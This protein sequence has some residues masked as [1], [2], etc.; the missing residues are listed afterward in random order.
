MKKNIENNNALVSNDSRYIDEKDI[1]IIGLSCRFPGA[2]NANE[3]WALLKHKKNSISEI[4]NDRWDWRQYWGDPKSTTNKTNIKWGGFIK[5]VDKFDP[6]FFNISPKEAAYM[7][8]QHRLFLQTAWHAIEDAGY[9]VSGL[10]GK[11]IGVYAGVSKNDYSE[12]MREVKEDIAPFISTGTVHS[13]LANRLSFLFDFHG[14][15]MAIDT[16][17]SSGLV[18][19]HNAVR[20]IHNGECEAAIVGAVNTLL[21]PT[22]YISHSKSGFLST[23][24]Q[25]YSFDAAANGYV[26]GEGV[27]V[28]VIKSLKKALAD[29]DNIHAVVKGTAINHG[30]RANFL[31]SPT[32][33][34]QA[35]VISSAIENAGVEPSSI[36]YIETHGTGTP[37]GDPIE[38]N[39]LKKAFASMQASDS[40]IKPHCAISSVKTNIGHLESVAGIA[41][42]IKVILAMKNKEIPALQNFT[43][44]NPYVEL[45][46]SPFYL[47]KDNTIWNRTKDSDGEMIPRRAGVSSFGMGGVNAHVILQEAPLQ[48]I[49]ASNNDEAFLATANKDNH[50]IPLSM[51]RGDIREYAKSILEYLSQLGQAD[52]TDY[53]TL[54]D[55]AYTL[56]TGREQFAQRLVLVVS[57]IADL[58]GKLT[59]LVDNNEGDI[60]GCYL[61]TITFKKGEKPNVINVAKGVEFNA[62]ALQWMDGAALDWS[63]Y[64]EHMEPRKTPLP[65]YPFAKKR[66]WYSKNTADDTNNTVSKIALERT[67]P[68]VVV[69]N[70]NVFL[71]TLSKEQFFINDHVVQGNKMLPGVVYL[72]FVR[73]AANYI[74][75]SSNAN[76]LENVFWMQPIRVF[77]EDISLKIEFDAAGLGKAS[78]VDTVDFQVSVD[79]NIHSKG[80]VGKKEV[81]PSDF[82]NLNLDHLK[83][84]SQQTLSKSELYRLFSKNGL[85]YGPSFQTIEHC[86]YLGDAV[87]AELRVPDSVKETMKRMEL[88]PSMADGVFQ[89]IVAL[90]LLDPNANSDQYVPFFLE[91][92]TLIKPITDKCY[93]YATFSEKTEKGKQNIDQNEMTFDAILCDPDGEPLVMVNGLT[94][95]AIGS[96]NVT[97][98][99]KRNNKRTNRQTIVAKKSDIYY[100]SLWKHQARIAVDN[101]KKLP[102]LLVFSE[103]E[104]TLTTISNLNRVEGS[105]VLITPGDEFSVINDVHLQ[106]NPTS[107]EDF[108]TL[109][110]YFNRIKLEVSYVLYLWSFKTSSTGHNDLVN[111]GITNMLRFTKALIA[112]RTYKRVKLLY[113][114]NASD[115]IQVPYHAM[116]GGFARTLV[117]ENP[118]M[119]YMTLGFEG[120]GEIQALLPEQ[121]ELLVDELSYDSTPKLHELLYRDDRRFEGHVKE[122]EPTESLLINNA[123]IKQN[124]V[125]LISGGAGGLGFIFA[126]HL[127][128]NYN[129]TVVLVGRS[130][131]NSNIQEK[132]N[133]INDLGGKSLYYST[134]IRE[135]QN[136]QRLFDDV[137]VKCQQVNGVI[138]AAGVIEDAYILRKKEDIF[139]KVITPKVAGLVHM[140]ELSSELQLDFFMMFSSIASLM[141]NQGQSDYAAANSFLDH[142]VHY[143]NNLVD[144]GQRYGRSLV[145]NWPLWADGGMRVTAEETAHLL[146]VFGMKPL[147]T[148]Q[149]IHLF[150]QAL[151][152]ISEH[153]DFCQL[154]AIDGDKEKIAACLGIESEFSDQKTNDAENQLSRPQIEKDLRAIFSQ[155]F[156][157]AA[158]KLD[159]RASMNEFDVDSLVLLNITKQIN[160]RYQI[161]INP[162]AFFEADTIEKLVEFI[163][164]KSVTTLNKTSKSVNNMVLRHNSSLINIDDSDLATMLFCRTFSTSEFY[165]KDH[166]VEEQY[167]MPGACYIEMA[168]QAAAI[169]LGDKATTALSHNFWI[170]QLSSPQ[171]NF[172]AFVEFTV[173]GS[174]YDYEV[175]S[176]KNIAGVKEKEV[177]AIGQVSATAERQSE[178]ISLDIDEVFKRCKLVQYPEEVYRQIIAE[179]LHVGPTFMPM[180]EIRLSQGEAIG[181][182]KLPSSIAHTLLDYVLH[183]T[184]LTGFFQTALICNRYDDKSDHGF[185]YIPIG[186]D[187]ITIHA[188]V[189]DQCYVYAKAHEQNQ[190]NKKLR[191]YDIWVCQKNG[192]V[193]VKLNGFA[194]R[195]L[196]DSQVHVSNAKGFD[197]EVDL[198]QTDFAQPSPLLF[199]D[200]Q[201]TE[202]TVSY[203]K[204]VLA[205]PIGLLKDEIQ[206]NEAFESY[207]INSI[208]IVEL[209]KVLEDIFGPLS[210][211]LFFE[212]SNLDE[213]A[214]F[215]VDNHSETL[216]NLM[217]TSAAKTSSA[218][219]TS[220]AAITVSET[221]SEQSNGDLLYQQTLTV[222]KSLLADPI[223]LSEHELQA[224]EAFE[225]Y[226]INS[227]MIV[228]LNKVL[229]SVFGPLSKT[230]FFEYSNLDELTWFFVDNHDATLRNIIG[231]DKTNDRQNSVQTEKELIAD[232]TLGDKPS[233]KDGRI[234]SG[235]VQTKVQ[236]VDEFSTDNSSEITS[237]IGGPSTLQQGVNV[238]SRDIAII[239]VD[240][241]YPGA[242]TM[243]EF[244]EMLKA[245]T[246]CIKEV[247]ATHFESD[248]LYDSLPENDRI[249]TREGGFIDDVDK[250]DPM[251]FNISPREAELI[252]P[253]ERLF[254]QTA[255][256]MLEDAGYT[257]KKLASSVNNKVGVF[258]GALWQPYQS[259]GTEETLKGN[260][261][262]PSGLLYSIANRVSYFLNLS[263]PSLAIDTACSS[264]L[265]ALHIACQSILNDDCRMAIAGGVNLSLH[266]SKYLYL[267]QNRF[268]ASDGRCRSFGIGGDGYVPGEGVGAILLKP[269]AD[270]ERD[271]DQIYAVI[272]G[273]AINHG[274]KTNGYT[275]PNP[276]AQG[277]MIKEALTRANVDPRSISYIE[278]HGTGTPLG[279]PIEI[280]GLNKAFSS[281]T[282]DKQFCSIGSIKAN[283]GHLEAA[284]GIAAVSKVIL[285]MKHR[286]LVPSIHSDELSPNIDFSISPFKVQHKLEAWEQDEALSSNANSSARRAGISSFGAGG[287]NAHVIL[288]EYVSQSNKTTA[289]ADESEQ[290][291]VLS[292][293]TESQLRTRVQDLYSYLTT[294]F[295]E[296]ASLKHIELGDIA[297]TLQTGRE[298]MAWRMALIVSDLDTLKQKIDLYINSNSIV[299][300]VFFQENAKENRAIVDLLSDGQ[301]GQEF[302]KA[303][304]SNNELNKVA[305]FWVSGVDIDWSLL[306][307]STQR[308]II[309]LPTYPFAKDRYWIEPAPESQLVTVNG[310]STLQV[311][312]PQAITTHLHPLLH[313]NTSTFY[314]QSYASSFDGSET[315]LKDH[316]VNGQKTLPGVAYLEMVYEAL[317]DAT[318]EDKDSTQWALSNIVWSRP[319]VVDADLIEV[320]LSLF[321]DEEASRP[322]SKSS[323]RFEV[324]SKPASAIEEKKLVLHCQ[325]GAYFS[326]RKSDEIILQ[327]DVLKSQFQTNRME[328]ET[329]YNLFK[330]IGLDYGL[331]HRALT[332]IYQGEGEILGKILLPSDVESSLSDYVLHPSVMDAALQLSL[333][334]DYDGSDSSIQTSV[335]FAL[336]EIKIISRCQAAMWAKVSFTSNSGPSEAVRKFDISL[337]DEA[338]RLCI[339]ILG[340][341][342]RLMTGQDAGRRETP[343]HA[344]TK[345][346]ETPVNILLEPKWVGEE[347]V[348]VST[349]YQD[350]YILF[351]GFELLQGDVQTLLPHTACLSFKSTET[352]ERGFESRAI[353]LFELLQG[354]LRKKPKKQILFQ[355]LIEGDEKEGVF[356]E[357]LGAILSTANLENSKIIGQSISVSSMSI[358]APKLA[359][360]LEGNSRDTRFKKIRYTNDARS[361]FKFEES[362]DE[363]LG[364]SIEWCRDEGVYLISGGLG[365]LGLIFAKQ[366]CQGTTNATLILTG[367]SDLNDASRRELGYLNEKNTRVHYRKVD[368]IDRDATENLV[369]GITREF[370]HL[371]G[372]IHAAGIN[373]DSFIINKTAVSF[374]QV[375]AP[376]TL[377]T[378]NL[379]YASRDVDLEFFVL[380]SSVTATQGNLGQVDYAAANAF[381]DSFADYRN[382]LLIA[383]KR[384]GKSTSIN[385]PLWKHG[386][387]Q[388]GSDSEQLLQTKMGIIPMD[389]ES[390][391]Q[392]YGRCLSLHSP[393]VLV[394]YGVAADIRKRFF[395]NAQQIQ[396]LS[397]MH[398]IKASDGHIDSKELPSRALINKLQVALLEKVSKLLKVNIEELDV[399]SELS[400]YGFDSISLTSFSNLLNQDYQI[401]LAPT[402]FFEY[403]TITS[404]T[405]Y[406]LEEFPSS[407]SQADT[408]ST[409]SS[410]TST[411]LDTPEN[412]NVD[413]RELT[414]EIETKLLQIISTLL[415]VDISELDTKTELSDF[416]FDSISLT[417]F[418][419]LINKDYALTLAPTIF[420]EYPCVNEL[421]CYFAEAF[422][423][424]FIE[425]RIGRASTETIN[426]LSSEGGKSNTRDDPTSPPTLALKFSRKKFSIEKP[427]PDLQ[428]LTGLDQNPE[429]SL[430]DDAIAIIGV[431][432]RFPEA[433]NIKEFWEN[434]TQGKESITEIPS[435][436]WDWNALYGD[437]HK[438]ANKTNVK[439]GGFIDDVDKF[440]PLFFGISPREAE[441]M[442]PQQRLLMEYIWLAIE[443]AGYSAEALSGTNTGLFIGTAASGYSSLLARA[444]CE[445]EAYSSTGMVPS[446]GP[447]RMSHYLNLHGPSEPIETACSSSLVAVHRSVQAILAGECDMA[448]AGGIN[449]LISSD[450]H[451]SFNKAGMLSEDGHCKT[452]SNLANGYVRGEG[453]GMLILKKLTKAREDGDQV[454]GLIRGSAINHG[455]RANSLTAPNVKAQAQVIRSA[456]Q[457]AGIDPSTI[458]YIEAHGTGTQLGDPVE[459]NGLKSAFST[460]YADFGLDHAVGTHCGLGSVKTN[461]GHLEYAAG[462][463]GLIK[464]LLQF[465]HQTLFKSI[466]CETLNPYISFTDSPFY[467]VQENQKWEAIKDGM[468]QDLPR[469]G[470]VSSFGFGGVNAHVVLEEYQAKVKGASGG[471]RKRTGS[472]PE[473]FSILLSAKNSKQLLQK[474][475]SFRAFILSEKENLD[476]TDVAYTLQV[477]R[478]AM[479]E[480]LALMVSSKQT[481]VQKLQRFI[482][483]EDDIDDVFYGN[484]KKDKKTL[485]LFTSDDDFDDVVNK[486]LQGGKLNKVLGLWVKGLALDWQKLYSD[487]RPQKISLP[488]YPFAKDSYWPEQKLTSEGQPGLHSEKTQQSLL[489]PR[490]NT[491]GI[492]C[493]EELWTKA[494]R[495]MEA[496]LSQIN[497]IEPNHNKVTLCF[498]S[499][500]DKQVALLDAIQEFNLDTKLVFVSTDHIGMPA[501][502]ADKNNSYYSVNANQEQSYE[503]VLSKIVNEGF[504]IE[505]ILYFWPVDD[506]RWIQDISPIVWLIQALNKASVRP[507]KILLS[508]QC[509]DAIDSCYMQSWIGFERSL[510][511][512]MPDTQ[513][514]VIIEG[515]VPGIEHDPRDSEDSNFRFDFRQLVSQCLAELA[516]PEIRSV[517]YQ[518][519]QRHTLEIIESKVI[520]TNVSPFKQN[521]VYLITGGFGGL[522]L[523]F[524]EYLAENYSAK[525]ILTGRS[526]VDDEIDRKTQRLEMAGA[527]V[528]Y[529]QADTCDTSAMKAGIARATKRLGEISGVFAA[530]GIQSMQPIFENNLSDFKKVLAP[531]VEGAMML[532]QVLGDQALDFLCYFSSSSAILGDFGSCDYAIGNRFLMSYTAYRNQLVKQGLAQGKTFVINWPL[533]NTSVS[534]SGGGNVSQAGMSIGAAEQTEFY[535]RSS[536]QSLLS[537]PT[538]FAIIEQLLMQDNSQHLV[539][540]GDVER[541][542]RQVLTHAENKGEAQVVAS[543]NNAE[544]VSLNAENQEFESCVLLDLM[545]LAAEL[546]KLDV[547]TL[548]EESNLAD[549]GFDSFAIAGFSRK[550]NDYFNINLVPSLFFSYPTFSKLHRYL[551]EKYSSEFI[552]FYQSSGGV[553]NLDN[554]VKDPD[555]NSDTEQVSNQES[556]LNLRVAKDASVS[557]SFVNQARIAS[558]D[559]RTSAKEGNNDNEPLRPSNKQLGVGDSSSSNESSDIAIVGMSGRFPNAKTVDELWQVLSEGRSSVDDIPKERWDWR[560]YFIA[561]EHESNRIATNQGGFLSDIEAFDSLFFEISPREAQEMDPRQRILLESSWHALE[562]AGLAGDQIRGSSCGVFIGVEEGEYSVV[563]TGSSVTG[564]H[565]GILAARIS[566]FLDLNGPNLALNTACSS[567]LVALHQ[568][569]QALRHQECEI[570][571][572]GGVNLMH[573]PATYLGLN[574]M[575][576]LSPAG[577]CLTFDRAAS[578]MVPSEA[579]VVVVLKPLS[580]AKS[581]G[582]RI[583]AVI[584]GSGVNYDGRTNG[585]TA[586]SGL[587]QQKLIEGV[588][589]KFGIDAGNIDYVLAHGTGTRLGDPVEVNALNAAFKSHTDARAYCALGSLKTNFGHS[590]AASGLVS[591]VGALMAIKHKKIPPTANFENE[592][593]FIDFSNSPFF[594]PTK[595]HDWNKDDSQTRMAAISAFGMSGTNAH[596]V[597][598]EHVSDVA[599]LPEVVSDN[600]AGPVLVVLSAAEKSQ[601]KVQLSELCQ[602][603][604]TQRLA[605]TTSNHDLHDL[606][607][608]LQFGRASFEH[609]IA[610]IVKDYQGLIETAEQLL[611]DK[612]SVSLFY[613]GQGSRNKELNN[614][615]V[616]FNTASDLLPQLQQAAQQWVTG[617]AVDWMSL[618]QEVRPSILSVPGYPFIKKHHPY[619]VLHKIEKTKNALVT[620]MHVSGRKLK[621]VENHLPL[622]HKVTL[623]DP[624]S[625]QL[626]SG[627]MLNGELKSKEVST[628]SLVDCRQV[629]LGSKQ[630][631]SI[632]SQL[633]LM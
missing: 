509:E 631:T 135:R 568:A 97:H 180:Q 87:L 243:Q 439:W 412:L 480:R 239:G 191:K 65:T 465:K 4:P 588:Y 171:E 510:K 368:V 458:G 264:S 584:K 444:G 603:L 542:R 504:E 571:L 386:G 446:I 98:E 215:F 578:G 165:L 178:P 34:A 229:E 212:Y 356:V 95:R 352:I 442:D 121:L 207:G 24:G 536:G 66:C 520:N 621:A 124:G 102:T 138:H 5:D 139:D 362:K 554:R 277:E 377:G 249:Y 216:G 27:G 323:I 166:V 409:N 440:D 582:D 280:S 328:I 541:I 20:D 359:Q 573:S 340:L 466:N 318:S 445:V 53:K 530:A 627:E 72:E 159:V 9:C 208:M 283:I 129:A 258:V 233:K 547:N 241:V 574:K 334:I 496:Q 128:R 513:C 11:K 516:L 407:F 593:E 76:T 343:I 413:V 92:L 224:E 320:Q 61:S 491:S 594:V 174:G 423:E 565:N 539:M 42:V 360:Y 599:E 381:M 308:R 437:P 493:F 145:I 236:H 479:D 394:M 227:I 302:I 321:M 237:S 592:N 605:K 295:S 586:P 173:K 398:D 246:D 452:F 482:D 559:I 235:Q 14:P 125:Y 338:G 464:V 495:P 223:G 533:W 40:G 136:V 122:C 629:R 13:I 451:I 219:K 601:L 172:V 106:I 272:K 240:G 192:L 374:R 299:E 226:G 137:V 288:E 81:Q 577:K 10:S 103:N 85:D 455:G 492:V 372:V 167:N 273:S 89:T 502:N 595:L 535:L 45:D 83:G 387:M 48:T 228:E 105:V 175:F 188:E 111:I 508:G 515:L 405:S 255:W 257:R 521:G 376:K 284:A 77:D 364:K 127:S 204:G 628:V 329:S 314:Q 538:G 551:I 532:D 210:K 16:A 459:I 68:A 30:G 453:V 470:G 525:L 353:Q 617:A 114:Y 583:Y 341:S 333:L 265:T 2:E 47:V 580:K 484:A 461:I 170:S 176:Y 26:R 389:T 418:V 358:S 157:L 156:N 194:I 469:R 112:S 633:K 553:K 575:G 64:Y 38:I 281:F 185:R 481:L 325:G 86:R 198:N 132:L 99:N 130:E 378:V 186:I 146:K 602:W 267:C 564:G 560:D 73:D 391:I 123:T 306:H 168:R 3:F 419:N 141:P 326:R 434:L 519:G 618:Y 339:Q 473:I 245:G 332:E 184:M 274:G 60:P 244:W 206:D 179:G 234:N 292:A 518:N 526:Q 305:K 383:G 214:D 390:G 115:P 625:V 120:P 610:F 317:S 316:Q 337:F 540:S 209:N 435:N 626:N 71:N 144:D 252:D 411:S 33:D 430:E 221:V 152:E 109:A 149:G 322:D 490:D 591:L 253:Q 268:L 297:Y 195:A 287:A 543:L 417:S 153:K 414:L 205:E 544:L 69:N 39:G 100:Q 262:A 449:T 50:F 151:R 457:K 567:G 247:P 375:L 379:D 349:D 79:G 357:A 22:M 433:K 385:W 463:A 315:F 517:I 193:S 131:L 41:G 431:S 531:K 59:E 307:V 300:N 534:T 311:N 282:D 313:K 110:E 404:L 23:D 29:G 301:A 388:I 319:I 271:G 158:E 238:R 63:S 266:S 427:K 88:H 632:I 396:P 611:I 285:Q 572:A 598:A 196:V 566:Y 8:P 606:T 104:K 460:M 408:S 51:K 348:E 422:Q 84:L 330:S 614:K 213:L 310:S 142:Y 622:S 630:G 286:Q 31:T 18:A 248:S 561:P 52:I 624:N 373:D 160:Q 476:L 507:Q 552:A 612:D 44:I 75:S 200:S 524:A 545:R 585:I 335:P 37:M 36:N 562:D 148:E 289:T 324:Y 17:C 558:E 403:P 616:S 35:R 164:G 523:M 177:H 67:T 197:A 462:M 217:N 74:F 201:L 475:I 336:E 443:D 472:E 429:N 438:E 294:E 366:I 134:D 401:D 119:R 118:N 529:I 370:G 500:L 441:L 426:Q 488:G 309:S 187:E 93:V 563:N 1:A 62:L 163:L 304:I 94:K 116:V 570:A 506:H 483:G 522:G 537:A 346:S 291:I 260:P 183:P 181:H 162:T 117:Y 28:L 256:G 425:K 80:Q 498:L 420:F 548:D 367:R 623:V 589:D 557:R 397:D 154:F 549:F 350:H 293:R 101:Q 410:S 511:Q 354:I 448:I 108:A 604:E 222:L 25:C 392:A 91:K 450:L 505:N 556:R 242:N 607:F 278:A 597:I 613:E 189:G 432:A 263:G 468:G 471:D 402:L 270:A 220:N 276:N 393:Q 456:Y 78:T 57:D 254:L 211:T 487:E 298:S 126:K 90:S 351:A 361:V 478:E 232:N 615:K 169:M 436:R 7:D 331:S 49:N 399:E 416:G 503:H 550:L 199:D 514:A 46:E 312:K 161:G 182:L 477:G 369:K 382:E 55:I 231:E 279:D 269:L 467:L 486:W 56:Q 424:A 21:A 528:F 250:F 347:L 296:Q 70:D 512:V 600:L 203:L 303:A 32:V 150:E 12:L 590:L 327:L 415:K 365:G 371:T 15:S 143:R 342:T 96:D 363:A 259:I 569:C 501:V 58:I 428:T 609:R 218:T 290:L 384:K 489:T 225:S 140:D 474:A 546:L 454:Y 596:V 395:A 499:T 275:V 527:K 555:N 107:A 54:S 619:T 406:L 355:L 497:N 581:D 113:C 587:S 190:R 344:L 579:A 421:A 608:T 43:S 494:D 19:L 251:F 155:Q 202:K 6:L 230:L 447:N 576:M 261:V 485:G 620:N 147:S 133:I 345:S 380:F 400:D 82:Q